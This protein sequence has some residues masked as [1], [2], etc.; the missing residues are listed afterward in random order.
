MKKILSLVGI[1]MIGLT[2]KAQE[3]NQSLKGA[4]FATSQIGYQ[5][6][7]TGDFKKT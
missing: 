3:A 4:W 2:A 5:Q 6:T 7:K 1:V